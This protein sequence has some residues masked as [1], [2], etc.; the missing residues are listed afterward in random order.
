MS[1]VIIWYE[2]P[3]QSHLNLCL[4]YFFQ[5]YQNGIFWLYFR[6]CNLYIFIMEWCLKSFDIEHKIDEYVF[7]N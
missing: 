5:S 4:S 6:T 1:L 7:E 3:R 2:D